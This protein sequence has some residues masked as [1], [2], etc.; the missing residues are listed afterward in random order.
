MEVALPLLT[1]GGLYIISNKDKNKSSTQEGFINTD[2][3][4]LDTEQNYISNQHS[5]PGSGILIGS[6][7]NDKLSNT[8]IPGK[9]LYIKSRLY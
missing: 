5:G 9:N 6:D 8:N 2:I 3:K 1:L 7:S 4:N